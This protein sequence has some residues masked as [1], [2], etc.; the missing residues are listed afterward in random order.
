MADRSSPRFTVLF[1]AAALSCASPRATGQPWVRAIRIEGTRAVPEE[2]IK[3]RILTTETGFGPF[4]ERQPF[5]PNAWEADLR[6]IERLYQAKGFYEARVV[7]HQVSQEGERVYLSVKVEEGLP[8]K[9]ARVEL[10]GTEVLSEGDRREVRK[11]LPLEAGQVFKEEAWN[12]AKE[13]L[14][15][16]LKE[17]AY[18]EAE[19]LGEARVD[20]GRRTAELF[21]RLDPGQRY[22]FGEVYV[23]AAEDSKVSRKQV[24]DQVRGALKAGSWYSESALAEAQARVFRMGVFGAVKVNRGA[25]DRAS[26][27]IPVVVDIR[28]APFQTV[29][30]GG[31]VGADQSRND[32]R[33]LAEYTHRNAFGGLRKVTARV[34]GGVAFLPNAYA[35]ATAHEGEAPKAGPVLSARTEFEQPAFIFR[36]LRFQSSLEGERGLEQAYEYTGGRLRV[37]LLWQPHPDF[38]I[39][40]SYNLEA[41]LLTGQALL[42]GRSPAL[43]FGC[44]E[45]CV[46]SYLDQLFEWDRRNN[47][48]EPERG[49]Y[50]ALSLQEGGGPLRGAFTFVRVLPEARAYRS[51]VEDRLT[52]SARV[53]LGTLIPLGAGA[54]AEG[55][56][57]PIVSRFFSGGNAM[58]GFGNRRLSPLWVVPR[59]TGDVGSRDGLVGVGLG[60]TV[61]VGGNGLFETS[62]EARYKLVGDLSV[63]SFVDTGFVTV[64]SF[65]ISRPRYVGE[66]LHIA[67]GA[68]ARYRTFIGPIRLDLAYRPVGPP[69]AVLSPTGLP[70]SYPSQ[71]GCFG[72]FDNRKQ[73]PGSPEGSC[74]IH[75]SIG[76]AF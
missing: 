37:G 30:A 74:S 12:R 5:E 55:P 36:Y 3:R 13:E 76:E 66:N 21:L 62:F 1:V 18:A 39:L 48:I 42:G 45:L 70:L 23:T 15:L 75:I 47:R 63:A 24:I 61:P 28:E 65:E 41:Y 49:H 52:L 20:V 34:K 25:P 8:V 64:Q 58:R 50:L 71:G 46:L 29:K 17:L 19:V 40:P 9:I 10:S 57:S 67:V 72:L 38:S 4:A 44:P 51:F 11:A 43:S 54:A 16:T 31:G 68:G 53:K 56:K 32:V 27:T 6:R 22:R 2:E 60:E 35:W 73:H 14:Q 69:L 59:Y 7:D 33:A 26:G